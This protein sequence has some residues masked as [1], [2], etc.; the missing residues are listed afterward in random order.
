MLIWHY[1]FVLD[2]LARLPLQAERINIDG[3][4]IGISLQENGHL[5][6]EILASDHL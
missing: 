3:C 4:S 1:K 5:T 2:L 6:S